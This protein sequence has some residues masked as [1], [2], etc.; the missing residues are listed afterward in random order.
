VILGVKEIPIDALEENKVYMFFSHTMK[1]QPH[2][3]PM[4]RRMLEIGCTLLD[5]ELVKD[6]DDVRTIAFG[7]Y[8]GHAGAIDTLWAL[9]KRLERAGYATGLTTLCQAVEYGQVAAAR[10][11]IEAVGREIA[12]RGVP[13]EIAPL[14]IGVTGEGGKVSGGALEV[15]DFL[16]TRRV[17]PDELESAIAA[18][19]GEGREILVASYGPGHLVEPLDE[20]DVYTWED[21]LHHP[22]KYRSRFAPHLSLLSALIHGILWQKGYPRFILRQDLAA[23]WARERRPKLE[24]ITD[25]TCDPD[26]SN[27]SLVRTTDPGDPVYVYDPATG[28]ATDGWDGN[29]PA[30]V[31]VEIFPA[32]IPMDS[33][34]HFSH[35]LSPL[36]PVL[37]QRGIDLDPEDTSLPGPLRGSFLAARG[38]LLPRWKE[39]LSSPLRRHGGSGARETS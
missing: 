29:G 11:A 25:V 14:V 1:G 39:E 36:V 15:L 4:L 3:M 37:A 5:Y 22:E 28:E 24:V 10:T 6:E 19:D 8:A 17:D 23:L 35:V 26:G 33:S 16:P 18:H 13:A 2:N 34:R 21:Y 20:R 7:R 27:E 31:P 12:A 30:V 9:G 38:E 32:E